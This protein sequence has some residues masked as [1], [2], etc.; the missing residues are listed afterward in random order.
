MA[1]RQLV[2]EIGLV[3]VPDPRGV[4]TGRRIRRVQRAHRAPRR[5][6][7]GPRVPHQGVP[8]RLR[9]VEHRL[10]P[11]GH[12]PP[13][14]LLRR[15]RQLGDLTR[16]SELRGQVTHG[17][18]E[19]I[20]AVSPVPRRLREPQRLDVVPLRQAGLTGV[21]GHIAGEFRQPGDGG[22]EFTP[23]GFPVRPRQQPGDDAVEVVHDDRAHMPAAV[24]VVQV[25]QR[26]RHRA[27]GRHVGLPHPR[28]GRTG[29]LRV[30]RGDQ[31]VPARLDQR[32]RGDRRTGQEVP[33]PHVAAP[34]LTH[35]LDGPEDGRRELQAHARREVLAVGHADLVDR[36]RTAQLAA[37]RLGDDRRRPPSRLLSA[38]P[39]GHGR[40][41]V[42]QVETVLGAAHVDPAGQPGVRA[43]R[44]LDE[45][46]Q[47]FVRL[48]RDKWPCGH[49]VPPGNNP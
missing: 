1:V 33:P 27:H 12:A 32:G 49:G 30:R 14:P 41:V 9:R 2:G 11:R 26:L 29:D 42:A 34:Q 22:E 46:L 7:R 19:H 38:Q 21:D 18:G 47:P 35:L 39:T 40:L 15:P 16:V 3:E 10:G 25:A 20:A 23:H 45:R 43:P 6:L 24:L 48:P 37:Q 44:L 8:A 36:D 5:E 17:R 28:P 13:C 4:V 31:P